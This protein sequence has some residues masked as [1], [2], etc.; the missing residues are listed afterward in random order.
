[1]GRVRAALPFA[2]D[3]ATVPRGGVL[4][5]H[6]SKQA[7][8]DT[9]WTRVALVGVVGAQEVFRAA[10]IDR[11]GVLDRVC[12]SDLPA[13]SFAPCS[14]LLSAVCRCHPACIVP[15]ASLGPSASLSPH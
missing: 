14:R 1:M 6:A 3:P 13:P 10:D 15:L 5:Y 4:L 11:S 12:T 9:F 7:F 2:A 8:G